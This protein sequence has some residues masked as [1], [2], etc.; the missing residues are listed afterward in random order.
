[1]D[2]DANRSGQ[3]RSSVRWRNKLFFLFSFTAIAAILK[4]KSPHSLVGLMNFKSRWSGKSLCFQVQIVDW[5]KTVRF[6]AAVRFVHVFMPKSHQL[7]STLVLEVISTTDLATCVATIIVHDF[8]LKSFVILELNTWKAKE[9]VY[10]Q[11]A[12]KFNGKFF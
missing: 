11:L 9:K 3:V 2:Y 10:F 8:G 6:C 5:T 12:Q 1:M 4:L 7:C